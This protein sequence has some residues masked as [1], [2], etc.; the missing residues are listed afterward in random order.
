VNQ[1]SDLVVRIAA[2]PSDLAAVRDLWR[3]YWRSIDLPDEFQGFGEEL[4]SLPGVY[5]ADGGALLIAF[6]E[7]APAGTIALRRL[8][9]RAARSSACTCA[10][11]FAAG[12]WAAIYSTT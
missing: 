7:R 2:A 3:E 4:K 5:G 6:A 11:R 9:D 12:D 8:N 10:R 1:S